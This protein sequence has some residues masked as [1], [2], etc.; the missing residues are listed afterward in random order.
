[1][2]FTPV[3]PFDIMEAPTENVFKNAHRKVEE[4]VG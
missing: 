1:M 2:R 4:M 3:R